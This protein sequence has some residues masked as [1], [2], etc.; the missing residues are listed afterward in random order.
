M[1]IFLQYKKSETDSKM[2]NT[3]EELEKCYRYLDLWI[4][5][6]SSP[7][8]ANIEQEVDTI[9]A[10]ADLEVLKILKGA[11]LSNEKLHK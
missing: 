4:S 11:K 6:N 5:P 8:P 9:N 2:S 3:M 10:E 1:K 7:I